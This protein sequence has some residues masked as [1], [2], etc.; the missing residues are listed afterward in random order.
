[1]GAPGWN[2]EWSSQP[3]APDQ[4]G[5]DWFSLHFDSGEKLMLFQIR[6]QDGKDYRTGTWISPDGQTQ[7]IG[8]DEITM[9][10]VAHA[11]PLSPGEGFQH[12]GPSRSRADAC[13]LKACHSILKA[14]WGPPSPT[15]RAR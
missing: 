6:H 14:G 8:R 15:G 9:N 7:S 5:W 1:M 4:K 3:L 10:P 2:R 11:T 12:A 13:T